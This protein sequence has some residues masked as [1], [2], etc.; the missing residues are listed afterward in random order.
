L[1][2]DLDLSPAASFAPREWFIAF[3]R[4]TSLWLADRLSFGRY[5]HVSCFGPVP[6]VGGWL[7][8]DF[9]KSAAA[10]AVV[11]DRRADDL[12]G[13]ACD[14]AL[15]VRW[16]PPLVVTG[17]RLKPAFLCTSAVAHL[18]GVPSC[19]LRPDAFLRD[20]LAH[21]AEIV[22]DDELRLDKSAARPRL[23]RRAGG[24]EEREDRRD[25]VAGYIAD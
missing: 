1:D 22:I 9:G 7:F 2:D 11:P 13:L 23:A 3:K 21:G 5:K 18:T 10:I 14:R 6:A 4:T 16:A 12:M 8:Y 24:G 19:A 15:V 25:P 17:W 20:C